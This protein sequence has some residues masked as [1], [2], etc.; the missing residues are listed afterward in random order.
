[1]STSITATANHST[2]SKALRLLEVVLLGVGLLLSGVYAKRHIFSR[3]ESQ[4][5][6]RSFESA[7]TS[8][9]RLSDQGANSGEIDFSLWSPGRLRAYQ[10]SLTEDMPPPIAILKIPKIHLEV[11]VFD[12]TEDSALD[13]GVGRIVGTSKPGEQGNIGI[14]GH[15]D[16]FFRGLKDIGP[17]DRLELTTHEKSQVF[18]VDRIQVVDPSDVSVLQADEMP[19][20]TLVTCYP[21]YHV[22]SAPQRFIVRARLGSEILREPGK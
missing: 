7:Q 5:A 18:F 8:E 9:L 20:L 19:V 22:G 21:F 2:S 15:R 10:N 1:M 12:G 3:I 17:E 14:A 16:G 11:A 4:Q 6:V 13:R